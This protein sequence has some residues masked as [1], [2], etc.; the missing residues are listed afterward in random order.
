M[1]LKYFLFLIL[2]GIYSCAGDAIPLP[3][4][5]K[6][7]TILWLEWFD[8]DNFTDLKKISAGNTLVYVEDMQVFF[9][10]LED[11]GVPNEATIVENINCTTNGDKSECIYCCKDK[12]EETFILIKND[13]NW[14]VTDIIVALDDLDEEALKQERMLEEMLNKKLPNESDEL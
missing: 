14:K 10:G 4:T 11:D 3:E 8:N 2:I 12:E 7:T 13:G 1:N 5:P 9:E 6:E